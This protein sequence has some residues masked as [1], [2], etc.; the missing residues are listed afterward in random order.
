MV[1][2]DYVAGVD[3]DWSIPVEIDVIRDN[4]DY[5]EVFAPHQAHLA[6]SIAD[7]LCY[8]SDGYRCNACLKEVF[9]TEA[10]AWSYLKQNQLDTLKHR[11][12]DIINDRDVL[13]QQAAELLTRIDSRGI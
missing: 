11:F 5:G 9:N 6:D 7:Q 1:V 2:L 12:E 8:F 13:I 4:H 10:E 3:R